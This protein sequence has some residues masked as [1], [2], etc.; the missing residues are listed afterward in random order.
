M[1]RKV[2]GRTLSSLAALVPNQSA[3]YPRLC[4]LPKRTGFAASDTGGAA[5]I[6]KAAAQNQ[7]SITVGF[8]LRWIV[9]LLLLWFAFLSGE[10]TLRLLPNPL[11]ADSTRSYSK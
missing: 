2:A 9:I 6:S 1:T 7:S 3:S 11:V 4:P 5:L 8:A 10:L